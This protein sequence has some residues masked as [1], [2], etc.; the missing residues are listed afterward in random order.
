ML[1]S[2]VFAL[3]QPCTSKV[4]LKRVP[5]LLQSHAIRRKVWCTERPQDVFQHR[6]G[7][8][9][10]GRPLHETNLLLAP[11]ALPFVHLLLSLQVQQPDKSFGEK[12]TVKYRVSFYAQHIMQLLATGGMISARH[13]VQ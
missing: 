7:R 9:E 10:G 3:P 1:G 8:K 11:Q 6:V 5:R 2:G 4:R 12:A 13:K